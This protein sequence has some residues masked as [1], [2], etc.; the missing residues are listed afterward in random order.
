MQFAFH[1]HYVVFLPLFGHYVVPSFPWIWCCLLSFSSLSFH[2]LLIYIISSKPPALPQ[3]P[4]NPLPVAPM[5]KIITPFVDSSSITRKRPTQTIGLAGSSAAFLVPDHIC[6]KFADAWN[7]HISLTFL[8]IMA[9]FSKA[10]K[11]P[12]HS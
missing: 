5:Q 2:F 3:N 7:V 6:K 4:C 8:Q 1:T 11:L 10:N 9:A 12:I